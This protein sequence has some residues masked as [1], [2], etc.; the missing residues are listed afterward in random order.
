[1]S[2]FIRI[3]LHTPTASQ[4]VDG[5]IPLSD[6]QEAAWIDLWYERVRLTLV[7][8]QDREELRVGVSKIGRAHV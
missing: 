5:S 8:V 3:V 4:I 2:E 1:M 6:P 7:A